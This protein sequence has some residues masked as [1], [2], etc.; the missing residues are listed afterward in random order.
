MND[1]YEARNPGGSYFEARNRR[2]ERYN[3]DIIAPAAA[4]M[5][6]SYSDLDVMYKKREDVSAMEGMKGEEKEDILGQID[7]YINQLTEIRDKDFAHLEACRGERDMD[8][9]SEGRE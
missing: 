1:A 3:D 4:R 2:W 8:I 9:L 5:R 6:I 7:D